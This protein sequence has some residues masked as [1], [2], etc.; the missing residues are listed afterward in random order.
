VNIATAKPKP[1]PKPKL[2]VVRDV[3]IFSAGTHKGQPYTVD[4]L[5]D[6]ARNFKKFS[7]DG[8]GPR[9]NPPAVVGHE[10]DQEWVKD[11]GLPAAGWPTNL[12]VQGD[13]LKADVTDLPPEL[14][15]AIASGRYRA[16]SSEIYDRPPE[17]IPAKGKMLRRLAFLGG[18]LPHVKDIRRLPH[19]EVQSY[20]E[21]V[22]D[23]TA[24]PIRLAVN[25][26]QILPGGIARFF[27]EV[28]S[29]DRG[30][31]MK[32]WASRGVPQEILDSMDDKQL[33]A[34]TAAASKDPGP[35]KP[36]GEE[37][38][39]SAM[40]EMPWTSAGSSGDAMNAFKEHCSK[41]MDGYKTW[42]KDKFGEDAPV[43]I[44]DA[45]E[46]G[47]EETY[48]P[49][50]D[51]DNDA[52]DEGDTDNDGGMGDDTSDEDM[53]TGDEG[54]DDG[55]GDDENA[56]GGDDVDASEEGADSDDGQ[57]PMKK[58]KTPMQ[59]SE[60]AINKAVERAMAKHI[61]KLGHVASK[62]SESA[63]KLEENEIN[64][65]LQRML[66]EGRIAPSQMDPSGGRI[67]LYQKLAA[68]D[69]TRNIGKFHE[70]A[71]GKMVHMTARKAMMEEIAS[72]PA[73]FSERVKAQAAG[74]EIKTFTAQ[75]LEVETFQKFCEDNVEK[76]QRIHS[77][78]LEMVQVFKNSS[79][80]Q[81]AQLKAE[82]SA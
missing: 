71:T 41:M 19:P 58:K 76:L 8:P 43:G 31:M 75:D 24:A 38:N 42:H 33:G 77:T 48:D 80:E 61:G 15:D 23:Q 56:S 2:G 69:N 4:D 32:Q 66:H 30:E 55:T 54:T 35:G 60:D 44:H 14:A 74:G 6:I 39:T 51:G 25:R 82:L 70:S 45:D 18:D 10:E 34:L 62:F 12:R 49:D 59:F 46:D 57:T 65:F 63:A 17:G 13:K 68:A 21:S 28:I 20:S 1:W 81:R 79:K 52:T 5:H 26:V 50:N 73:K 64:G 36:E 53:D 67:T 7:G 16:V 37:P 22:L 40:G 78:P 11:T 72:Q 29:M 3:E 47:E 9:V 27:S